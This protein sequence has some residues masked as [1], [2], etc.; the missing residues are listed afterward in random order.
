MGSGCCK[1]TQI[2]DAAVAVVQ[3]QN[4]GATEIPF[5]YVLIYPGAPTPHQTY[6]CPM[7]SIHTYRHSAHRTDFEPVSTA[8]EEHLASDETVLMI[9]VEDIIDIHYTSDVKR[10]VKATEH[11]RHVPVAAQNGCCSC[12]DVDPEPQRETTVTEEKNAQRVITIH[13]QYSK[14]S[15]LDTVS[16]VRILSEADRAQFFKDKFQPN[17]ELKFFLVNNTEFN[18]T[19]FEQKKMQAENLCRIIM[20]LKG[21]N[22]GINN[23][24]LR[25]HT[26]DNVAVPAVAV[27]SYPS[28]QELQQIL[29]QPYYG[30]FG[31]S[32]QERSHSVQTQLDFGTHV[33]VP[34]TTTVVGA[35]EMRSKD[36]SALTDDN[37]S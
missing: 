32:H 8:K 29:N 19:N 37:N 5:G 22:N 20:Q 18:S 16:N 30:I 36:S 14:Y 11:S 9:P 4:V 2:Y 27:M 12:C 13:L 15:N 1:N 35:I 7:L 21:M 31:D 26:K 34:I 33:P 3:T 25:I 10:S 24:K 23:N 6:T 28:P 17:T